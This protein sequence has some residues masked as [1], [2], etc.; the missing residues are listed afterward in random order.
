MSPMV[1]EID[2]FGTVLLPGDFNGNGTVDTADYL[3]WRKGS[4]VAADFQTWKTNFGK[5]LSTGS[6]AIVAASVPEP[7]IVWPFL[8]MVALLGRRPFS[9]L[10]R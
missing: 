9:R 3:V 10:R 4:G 7:S 8:A 6:S 1:R 2:V 5:K